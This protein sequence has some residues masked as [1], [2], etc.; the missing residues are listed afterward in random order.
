MKSSL[1]IFL[2]LLMVSAGPLWGAKP[3]AQQGFEDELQQNQKIFE[4]YK[5]Q[6]STQDFRLLKIKASLETME[7]NLGKRNNVLIKNLQQIRAIENEIGQLQESMKNNQVS[8]EVLHAKMKG[9]LQHYIANQISGVTAPS[10]LAGS[11]IL[12]KTFEK[13]ME[14]LK[15]EADTSRMYQDRL[16]HYEK[17]LG[18]LKNVGNSLREVLTDLEQK[19][20]NLADSYV[21]VAQAKGELQGQLEGIRYK[22][23]KE[24]TLA[25]R[26][27]RDLDANLIPVGNEDLRFG[28]LLPPLKNYSTL[29]YE[30]KGV[31]FKFNQAT[32]VLS[33]GKGKVIYSGN[34]A[35][36]GN[37]IMIEHGDD[38]RSLIL[39]GIIPQIK[40]GAE[41]DAGEVIGF[42]KLSTNSDENTLY[43]EIRQKNIAQNTFL[44]FD[45]NIIASNL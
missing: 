33:V 26:K 34:L 20:R 8:M 18:G 19:K 3:R 11:R 38:L 12:I 5:N 23:K 37:V 43:F 35:S 24:N 15:K 29:N 22:V 6:I 39:G 1:P 40:K 44:W 30:N 7:Q 42:T 31:T 10:T 4:Q 27:P 32:P 9:T 25:Q 28:R 36:Y 41:V 16:T 17:S 21:E 14:L 45:K 13:Q 2:S